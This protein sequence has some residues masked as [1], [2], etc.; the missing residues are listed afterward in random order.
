[1]AHFVILAISENVCQPLMIN[2]VFLTE[3]T[4]ASQTIIPPFIC[5]HVYFL[6]CVIINI[7]TNYVVPFLQSTSIGDFLRGFGLSKEIRRSKRP[8]FDP[9]A[10]PRAWNPSFKDWCMRSSNSASVSSWFTTVSMATSLIVDKLIPE[11]CL[12][13][14]YFHDIIII[15][16]FVTTIFHFQQTCKHVVRGSR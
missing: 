2:V 16:L 13:H 15:I 6:N 10:T 9:R 14:C 5:L 7:L 4:P 12:A 11:R 1:M 3:R 8:S